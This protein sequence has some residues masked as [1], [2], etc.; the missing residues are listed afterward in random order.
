MRLK[1]VAGKK[2]LSR[3]VQFVES[4]RHHKIVQRRIKANVRREGISVTK[5]RFW[6]CLVGCFATTMNRSDEDAPVAKF[7]RSKHPLLDLDY[8]LG[9]K[10][11]GVTSAEVLGQAGVWRAKVIGEQI[12]QAVDTIR[13]GT[14][15]EIAMALNSIRARSRPYDDA[16]NEREV[17]QQLQGGGNLGFKGIGPK[18]SRNFIQWMGLSQYEIPIDSRLV[19]VLSSLEFPIPLSASALADEG[20]YTFVLDHLQEILARVKILPC[21]FDACAFASLEG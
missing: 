8:C 18:Q 11:L 17:A 5:A 2:D 9:I 13:T 12:H 6:K 10:N 20:Y 4:N 19:K 3:Y 14:W 21:V 15:P 7:L 1:L 16:R